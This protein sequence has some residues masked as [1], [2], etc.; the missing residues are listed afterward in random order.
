MVTN[1]NPVI[2]PLD[3]RML[4]RRPT[5]IVASVRSAIEPCPVFA[6]LADLSEH[7]CKLETSALTVVGRLLALAITDSLTLYGCVAWKKGNEIGLAF[8]NPLLPDALDGIMA[9][10]PRPPQAA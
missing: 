10:G 4:V 1:A 3:E 8:A 9:L 6:R 2:A 7:G 5:S